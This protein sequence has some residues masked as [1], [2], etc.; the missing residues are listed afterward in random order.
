MDKS[1]I[2][3]LMSQKEVPAFILV[4]STPVMVFTGL[5]KKENNQTATADSEHCCC[6]SPISLQFSYLYT[7]S[8]FVTDLI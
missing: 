1:R 6:L 5:P 4:E 8:M 7:G 2:K 3:G